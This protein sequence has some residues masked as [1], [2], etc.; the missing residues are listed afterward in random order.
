MIGNKPLLTLLNKAALADPDVTAL[1]KDALGDAIIADCV[2]G[3][4]IPSVRPAIERV[5]SEKLERYESK[6]MS[7]RSLKAMIVGIP[8]VGKSTLINRLAGGKKAKAEDRPGVT[9][10]KQ[11]VPTSIGLDLLD[12]PGVL[13]P[14]FEEKA[15]GENLA[16]TG[17]INDSILDSE[18]LAVVLCSRLRALYPALLAER[19]K[20]DADGDFGGIDDYELFLSI[21]RKRGFILSGGRVNEERTAVTLLDEFRGSKIGRI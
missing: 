18:T 4:G 5:L 12:M 1:W 10:A 19:Y 14:K 6:G 20:L 3:Q 11:W 21:G 17:A 8:N 16:L 13:W 2:S 15:V 9:L 7:G